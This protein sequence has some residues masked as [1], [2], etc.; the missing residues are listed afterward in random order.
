MDQLN[1]SR[2]KWQHAAPYQNSWIL[3]L[4]LAAATLAFY[5]PI[6]HNRFIDF[7]DEAYITA[8]PPVQDGLTRNTV[9]WSFTTFHAG[10][11]HPVTWLSH[12]LDCQIFHLNPVGHHYVNLIFHVM[13]ALLLF[14]LLREAT[15]KTGPS[16]IVAALF[17]LHPINVE[18]VAWAAERKNVLSML[19]FLLAMHAYNKY[20][21]SGRRL[22]Y[23]AVT[24]LFALGLMAKP[25]IVTLP[26]VLLLWDYWPLERLW[27]ADESGRATATYSPRT[28]RFLLLEKLPLFILAAADSYVIVLAQRAAHAVRA[29]SEVS[30]QAR[31]ENAVVSYVRY[32]EKAFWP[33][34]LAAMYPR[35]TFP[36]WQVTGTAALLILLSIL[37]LRW[38]NRRYLIVGWLWFL[39]T[40]VPMIGIITVGEQ[41]MADRFAYIPLIG[42]LIAVVWTLEAAIPQ[43]PSL[44]TYTA[45]MT[46]AA[47]LLLGCLTYRQLSYWHDDESLWRYT[48]SVTNANYMAESG[49]A[50]ALAKAGR[51][52][53]AIVHFRAARTLHQYPAD[54]ILWLA[55]YE[56]RVGHPT[57][58]IEECRAAL[59][60]SSAPPVRAAALDEMRQAFLELHRYDEAEEVA[61]Q[62]LNPAPEPGE[63]PAPN[64]IDRLTPTA[65]AAGR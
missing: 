48:L 60:A 42:L 31:V 41:A 25:Q 13:N 36:V 59:A 4:A 10:Y 65:S 33:T 44:R 49:L 52:D 24:F 54:Q 27:P 46:A 14:L 35:E 62:A 28:L 47:M 38:H 26:F 22:F 6:V 51:A 23:A 11:W 3:C 21:R 53:E 9:T 40:L 29:A 20:A 63:R 64:G 56:L 57:E 55:H 32:I 12:A 5:N 17:A 16:F 34:R 8:N 7:D 18:S 15:G 43:S 30:W 1:S 19:F 50:I 58:A 39:G 2:T 37:A 45:G 61:R